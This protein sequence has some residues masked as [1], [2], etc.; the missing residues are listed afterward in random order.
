MKYS[1]FAIILL[2]NIS[3]NIFA[4]QKYTLKNVSTV[5][6]F[7]NQTSKELTADKLNIS[8]LKEIVEERLQRSKIDTVEYKDWKN[9]IGGAYLY[10]K[11]IPS[12]TYSGDSYAVYIDVE[13]YQAVVL[14]KSR[15]EENKIVHGNTWSVGKLMNC[16][17]ESINSCLSET[18]IQLIDIFIRDFKEVNNLQ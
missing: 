10:I 17:S 3:T 1:I 14:I 11:I 2:F 4:S 16:K 9:N 15:V 13:L 6:V 7:I 12:K 18:I 8:S 5:A